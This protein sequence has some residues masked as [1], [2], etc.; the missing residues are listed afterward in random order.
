M[1]KLEGQDLDKSTFCFTLQDYYPSTALI[2]FN[3]YNFNA[4]NET[5]TIKKKKN[6]S[7]NFSTIGIY[8]SQFTKYTFNTSP[9]FNNR[10]ILSINLMKISKNY[11]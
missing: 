2:N 11:K 6:S 7:S 3:Y 9:V 8:F 1:Q 10:C 4:V 5:L